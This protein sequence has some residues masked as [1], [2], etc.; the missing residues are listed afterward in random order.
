M[1]ILIT[2]HLTS[3]VTS[4]WVHV[5]TI[6]WSPVMKPRFTLMNTSR[7]KLETHEYMQDPSKH[8]RVL[9]T[10]GWIKYETNCH[11]TKETKKN[12]QCFHTY[13]VTAVREVEVMMR[14]KKIYV[15]QHLKVRVDGVSTNLPYYYPNE[16]NATV[17]NF[18]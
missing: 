10:T 9:T 18:P 11:Q 12:S 3:K 16:K 17:R 2:I 14:S 6:L 8:L 7:L 1:E 13:R 15:D 5:L 4:I